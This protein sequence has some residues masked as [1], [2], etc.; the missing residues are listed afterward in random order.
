MDIPLG[1]KKKLT[2]RFPIILK[3][4]LRGKTRKF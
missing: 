3:V 1:D 4:I 2:V